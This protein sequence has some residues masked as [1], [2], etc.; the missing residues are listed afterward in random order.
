MEVIWLLILKNKWHKQS[1]FKSGKYVDIW[2]SYYA[3]IN[4]STLTFYVMHKPDS[5]NKFFLD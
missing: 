5:V 1:K 3:Y 2:W 4:K